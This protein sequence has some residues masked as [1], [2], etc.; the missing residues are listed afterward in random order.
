MNTG[1][2]LTIYRIRKSPTHQNLLVSLLKCNEVEPSPIVPPPGK[3]PVAR[4]SISLMGGHEEAAAK[5]TL[6]MLGG[7]WIGWW[8]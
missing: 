2:L 7:H 6:G 8:R 5:P 1:Y 4:V 3:V